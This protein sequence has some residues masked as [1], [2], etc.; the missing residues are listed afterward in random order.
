MEQVGPSRHGRLGCV[1][2]KRRN[3]FLRSRGRP[4]SWAEKSGLLALALAGLLFFPAP[5]CAAIP[6]ALFVAAC[7]LAPMFP[8]WG[9]FYPV[10]SRGPRKNRQISLSFDDGPDSVSTPLL[11]ALLRKYDYPAT[12]FVTGRRARRYP[13]LIAA[14]LKDGHELGNHSYSHENCIMFRSPARLVR[15]IALTQ[16]VLAR[17]GVNAV[18]FRPPVGVNVPAYAEALH[19]TGLTVVNFSCRARD[20]GNRRLQGLAR[21]IV[22]R[23]RPGDLV[24]L[25][26]IA[27]Q[28]TLKCSSGDRAALDLWPAELEH[29]FAALKQRRLKVVPLTELCQC[30]GMRPLADA[31]AKASVIQGSDPPSA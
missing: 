10:I 6:L 31:R 9:F 22:T 8:G 27:P 28:V 17:H 23:I 21:R 3:L 4:L 24:L 18:F 25:H 30:S 20:M 13:E 1:Q 11:L 19:V 14:I 15:E 12:F 7:C 16:R 5:L 2:G 29:I 26:D